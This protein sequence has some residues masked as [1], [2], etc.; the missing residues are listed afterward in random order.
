[1]AAPRR[2][3]PW[4]RLKKETDTP[5]LCFQHFRKQTERPRLL[6]VTAKEMGKGY[7]S[8]MRYS[9]QFRWF[10]RVASWDAS[11]VAVEDK[12]VLNEAQKMAA[13]Q[14]QAWRAAR[15]L[16]TTTIARTLEAAKVNPKVPPATLREAVALLD[17]ATNY[18]RLITGEATSREEGRRELDVG[19][20][21]PG[22]AER[23]LD[24]LTKAGY[25][26]SE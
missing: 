18:E 14:L 9:S 6:T 12:V 4:E 1:M 24:L 26:D 20:L 2:R 15:I 11:I 7:P 10:E 23:L 13:E 17:K 3:D 25:T 19:K 5:W 16:A 21:E 8:I 22:D